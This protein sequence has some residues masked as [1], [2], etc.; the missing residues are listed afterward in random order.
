VLGE[1]LEPGERH[2]PSDHLDDAGRPSHESI[3]IKSQASRHSIDTLGHLRYTADARAAVSSAKSALASRNGSIRNADTADKSHKRVLGSV[4]LAS[5]SQQTTAD[6]DRLKA[7]R[8]A[9]VDA[10]FGELL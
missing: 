6:T 7:R 9:A 5:L 3:V 1:S 4:E 10:L 8:A 2:L